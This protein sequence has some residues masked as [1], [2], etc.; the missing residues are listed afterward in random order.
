MKRRVGSLAVVFAYLVASCS[1]SGREQGPLDTSH[2]ASS[3]STATKSQAP[4]AATRPAFFPSVVAFWDRDHGLLGGAL[5]TASCAR[6][7]QRC[8]YA[9]KRTS[10]G[11]RTWHRALTTA[12][13]LFN[14]TTL[15]D[16]RWAWATEGG[17]IAR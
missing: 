9:I 17:R 10:D 11:G 3:P 12:T 14:L 5:V 7:R 15:P 1:A 8:E 4:R 13:P 6:N 2:T 16:S